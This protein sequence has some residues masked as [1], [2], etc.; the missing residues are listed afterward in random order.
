MEGRSH[1]DVKN[2]ASTH[3]LKPIGATFFRQQWDESVSKI[4]A[5]VL[6]QHEPVYG[7]PPKVERYIQR[8]VYY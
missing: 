2:L 1:F 7:K 3:G 4:Y 8:T 6:K 5:E